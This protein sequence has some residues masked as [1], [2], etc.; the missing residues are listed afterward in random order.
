MLAE[1]AGT[2]VGVDAA[3]VGDDGD[4]AGWAPCAGLATG[5][6]RATYEDNEEE[7]RTWPGRRRG[8]IRRGDAER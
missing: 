4:L 8:W 7:C 6:N 3:G 1:D 2:G 5:S